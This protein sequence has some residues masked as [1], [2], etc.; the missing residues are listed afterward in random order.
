MVV[1]RRGEYRFTSRGV[2]SIHSLAALRVPSQALP[3]RAV[4]ALEGSWCAAA[5]ASLCSVVSSW[6]LRSKQRHRLLLEV[7]LL[8]NR[9]LL[10]ALEHDR[11][12]ERQDGSVVRED[13]DCVG[14]PADLVVHPLERVRGPD[15]SPVAL[16]EALEKVGDLLLGFGQHGANRWQLAGKGVD[17]L[18]VLG[19]HRV[20]RW[21]KQRSCGS[22]QGPSPG[23]PWGCGRARHARCTQHRCQLAPTKH[24]AM[25]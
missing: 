22:R 17:H 18:V 6:A 3:Q 13:P 10:M 21:L 11:G 5:F 16:L 23:S 4:E 8:G 7:A 14:A 12:D 15:R 24:L 25:V 19:A 1:E 20:R 9:Q 2:V